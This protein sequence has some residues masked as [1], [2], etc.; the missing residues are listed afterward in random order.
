MIQG[1]LKYIQLYVTLD[2]EQIAVEF[3]HVRGRAVHKLIDSI[4]NEEELPQQWK[5]RI[6][7]LTG[8]NGDK[9]GCSN[10]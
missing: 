2:I 10:Y 5:D 6:I 9:T 8:E 3:L 4:W 1:R 7:V